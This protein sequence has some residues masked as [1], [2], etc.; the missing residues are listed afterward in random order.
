MTTANTESTDTT[1]AAPAA[2]ATK[3]ASRKR[4]RDVPHGM[5]YIQSGFNNT[6]VYV[7][8]LKGD[9]VCWSSAGACGFKGS[10]KGTPFAAQEAALAAAKK[11]VELGMST[12]IAKVSGPGSGREGAIRSF[13]SVGIYVK[14]IIDVT[15]LPHN[16]VKPKKKPRK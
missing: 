11:A 13:D 3:G 16:G 7:T 9:V 2:T 12:I 1:T 8:D 4:K 6:T 15:S 5:V 14:E 10:R